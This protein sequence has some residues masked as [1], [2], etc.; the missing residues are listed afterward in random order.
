MKDQKKIDAENYF[1]E[2]YRRVADYSTDSLLEGENSQEFSG[3]DTG[4]TPTKRLKKD[5]FAAF[6]ENSSTVQIDEVD[7]YLTEKRGS[8]S[9]LQSFPTIAK[10]FKLVNLKSLQKIK[11]YCS[12]VIRQY[13][14]GLP[15]SAAVERLFST[16]GLIFVPKRSVLSDTVFEMLLFLKVNSAVQSKW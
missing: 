3:S 2:E 8:L 14:A 9:Q 15:A 13:N 12:F 1:K 6:S 16:A 10:I 11:M 4:S 7:Q 5:F